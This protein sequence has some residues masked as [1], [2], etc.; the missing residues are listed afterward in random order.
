VL[1]RIPPPIA[2]TLNVV[3]LDGAIAGAAGGW[4]VLLTIALPFSARRARRWWRREHPA[5]GSWRPPAT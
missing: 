5:R 3:A 1:L 4:V 2:L